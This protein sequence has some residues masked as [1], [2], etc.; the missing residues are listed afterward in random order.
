MKPT[1]HPMAR[2]LSI[3]FVGLDRVI[4]SLG[5]FHYGVLESG[6]YDPFSLQ[7]KAFHTLKCII[8]EHLE[9]D[10]SVLRCKNSFRVC[11]IP[12]KIFKKI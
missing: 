6:I 8:L 1:D 10:L 2:G 4:S 9:T 3:T 12:L 5:F 11:R 7:N